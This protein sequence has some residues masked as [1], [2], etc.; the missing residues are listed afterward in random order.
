MTNF[1]CARCGVQFPES[2]AP[3]AA[4]PICQDSRQY[5]GPNGQEWTTQ[6]DLARTHRNIIRPVEHGIAGIATQPSFAIGQ[7]AMLIE[8]PDGN[9]LWDCISFID[10]ESVRWIE[11]RGR[12][13][14]IVVSHPH[15]YS[16]VVDWSRR[17]GDAP[18]YLHAD[19]ARWVMRPDPCIVHWEGGQLE[20]LPGA[21]LVRVGGHF[22][23]STV[24]H[25]QSGAGGRGTLH[26]G[27]SVY[28]VADKRYV[29][30]MYSYPNLIPLPALAVRRI[31]DA[32]SPFRFDRIY[33]AWWDA[34][35]PRNAKK[36]VEVSARRYIDAISETSASEASRGELRAV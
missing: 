24:L 23:G 35:I 11:S 21:T 26:T 34:V 16:A 14:A 10:E 18:V 15:Y 31:A 8:T 2:D 30:F 6:Q 13:A 12:L 1:I 32:I 20:I 22:P 33:G 9:I 28:V 7:R 4:C 36:A 25:W 29:S 19:D 17:L 5:L 3:P 27:D